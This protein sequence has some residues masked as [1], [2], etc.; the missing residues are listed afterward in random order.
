MQRDEEYVEE[1]E[2]QV[3]GSKK[4]QEKTRGGGDFK[5]ENPDSCSKI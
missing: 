4:P 5:D 2:K 3:S 1:S